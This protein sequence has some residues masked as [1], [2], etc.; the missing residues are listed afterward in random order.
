MASHLCEAFLVR[1]C[2]L[3]PEGVD[4]LGDTLLLLGLD[5]SEWWD[6]GALCDL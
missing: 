1:R 4:A 2:V 3:S 5:D 6:V